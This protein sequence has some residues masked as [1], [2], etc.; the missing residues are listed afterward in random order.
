MMI[1]LKS[2]R[3]GAMVTA[4]G[5]FNNLGA[6]QDYARELQRQTPPSEWLYSV[7][8]LVEPVLEEHDHG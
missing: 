1:V 6:A 4:I 7:H 3:D 5:P 2:S 8:T